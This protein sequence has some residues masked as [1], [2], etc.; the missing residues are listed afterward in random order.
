MPENAIC[1]VGA[2]YIERLAN[3]DATVQKLNSMQLSKVT[4]SQHKNEPEE[5]EC[6]TL[7]CPDCGGMI[8][9]V[10]K[11]PVHQFRCQ[12]GHRFSPQNMYAAQSDKVESALW[13]LMRLFREREEYLT[14]ELNEKPAPVEKRFLQA[15]LKKVKRNITTIEKMVVNGRKQNPA[16]RSKPRKQNG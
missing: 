13:S 16:A 14:S 6:T 1:Y 7:T 3:I 2:D 5:V 4:D 12:I 15:E 9:L 8:S 10:N 11:G